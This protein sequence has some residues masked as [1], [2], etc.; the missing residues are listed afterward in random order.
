MKPIRPA[1][2][3][4]MLV[5]ISSGASAEEAH[6]P[7]SAASSV[8]AKQISKTT[9]SNESKSI[10]KMD[11]HIQ[12]MQEMHEKTLKAKTPEARKALM[13]EQMKVMQD[14]MALMN[15]MPTTMMD[16]KNGMSM[17]GAKNGNRMD[18][19]VGHQMMDM[20]MKMM[21]GMMQLLMDRMA[22]TQ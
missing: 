5:F 18:M 15:S 17:M 6:H 10:L 14:G 8:K 12:A 3:A 13:V 2:I 11:Q 21:E 22:A 19:A 16:A 7:A 20:R 1:V 9:V 4:T